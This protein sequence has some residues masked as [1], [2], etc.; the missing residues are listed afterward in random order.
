MARREKKL[1][2]ERDEISFK[3]QG[4]LENLCIE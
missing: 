2:M 3:R 4:D 1:E